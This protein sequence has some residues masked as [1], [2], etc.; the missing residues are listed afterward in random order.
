MRN[1]NGFTIVEVVVLIAVLAIIGALGYMA[2]NNLV[3]SQDSNKTADA[4]TAQT[5]TATPV[6]VKSSSDLEKISKE[7][8]AMSLEDSDSSSQF[9]TTASSF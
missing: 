7:L 9:D 8:D 1:K 6:V 4:S 2:Y 3:N 5:P